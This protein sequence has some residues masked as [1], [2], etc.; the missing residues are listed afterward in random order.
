MLEFDAAGTFVKGWGG[1]GQGYDW[2]QTE[3]GIFIDGKG[4]VWLSGNG[5]RDDQI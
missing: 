5:N 3:H 2:P 1:P 4:F